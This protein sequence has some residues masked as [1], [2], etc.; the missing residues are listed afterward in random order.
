MAPGHVLTTSF[1]P[2]TSLDYIQ[3]MP[4]RFS[5]KQ[6][7]IILRR[8][9]QLDE[10]GVPDDA[11]DADQVVAL[12]K[13][14]G[15]DSAKVRQAIA[16]FQAEPRHGGFSLPVTFV[17]TMNLAEPLAEEDWPAFVKLLRQT[18]AREGSTSELGSI[19]EWSGGQNDL[20]GVAVSVARSE[21]TVRSDMSGAVG[22]VS[23]VSALPILG[24]LATVAETSELPVWARLVLGLLVL[25]SGLWLWRFWIVSLAERRKRAVLRLFDLLRSSRNRLRVDKGM[26]SGEGVVPVEQSS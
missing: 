3:I 25:A 26:N 6:V 10:Q 8:A 7:E 14:V 21:V 12:G 2:K 23:I 24:T 15:L 16:D 18:F 13:E 22:L 20:D 4:G 11:L 17:Q 9:S 19:Q 1:K 5:D